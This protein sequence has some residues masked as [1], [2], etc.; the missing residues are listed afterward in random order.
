[1][2]FQVI[3][4]ASALKQFDALPDKARQRV[5][6]KIDLL[7]ENAKPDGA[8]KLSGHDDLWRLRFGKCRIVYTR[9]DASDVIRVLKIERRDKA[10]RDL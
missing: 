9:P 1:M 3:F 10:Y 4:K 2:P 6:K 7:Q 8:V 5:T